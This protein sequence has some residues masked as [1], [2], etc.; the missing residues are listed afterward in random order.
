MSLQCKEIPI[1]QQQDSPVKATKDYGSLMHP[2]TSAGEE[3]PPEITKF[4]VNASKTNLPIDLKNEDHNQN[5]R[6]K[7]DVCNQATSTG[8]KDSPSDAQPLHSPL[9]KAQNDISN[10]IPV[11]QAD[12][13]SV[14]V[15]LTDLC[16]SLAA[17]MQ[18]KK[19]HDENIS[20]RNLHDDIN[21]KISN[22]LPPFR[23]STTAYN[24]TDAISV[25]IF[26]II[27]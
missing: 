3:I 13:V 11:I 9:D 26:Q 7:P 22:D 17:W 21:V 18:Q 14:L 5:N 27:A 6:N 12:A 8:L 23:V 20:L 1:V 16:P 24:I 4:S 2:L 15:S 10:K 25:V 19:V